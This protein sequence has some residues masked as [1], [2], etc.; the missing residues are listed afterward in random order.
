MPQRLYILCKVAILNLAVFL[1]LPLAPPLMALPTSSD[2]ASDGLEIHTLADEQT[3]ETPSPTRRPGRDTS[4]DDSDDEYDDEE[5]GDEL[6]D[7]DQDYD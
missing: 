3:P 6:D 1:S 2:D 5:W 7:E 4:D